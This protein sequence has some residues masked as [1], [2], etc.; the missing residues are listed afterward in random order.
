MKKTVISYRF[1]LL[2]A[3]LLVVPVTFTSCGDDDDADDRT[4]TGKQVLAFYY[5]WYRTPG[6]TGHWYH[7]DSEGHDPD[8]Y[9]EPGRRDIAAIH[10]PTIGA[11]D[12]LDPCVIDH[13]IQQSVDAG[14]DAWII[15]WW[16]DDTEIAAILDRIDVLRSPLKVTAY[17]EFIPG[18][19]SQLCTELTSQEKI[20]A[21][22]T[23]IAGLLDSLAGH[24]AWYTIDGE[25]VLFVYGRAIM[26][27]LF[28][29]NRIIQQVELTHP[30]FISGDT[31]L[32]VGWPVVFSA[33]DQL[34]FYNP[35]GQ[36]HTFGER[37]L[38]YE[39]YCDGIRRRRQSCALTVIPGYDDSAL[40]SRQPII[41]DREGGALYQRLWERAI[42]ADPDWVLIT[43][44]NEWHEGSEIEPSLEYGDNYLTATETLAASFKTPDK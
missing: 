38:L 43:S 6:F 7:W 28:Q 40:P 26:H 33:F 14:I 36:I 31:A 15:S 9:V 16:G 29:W 10:Y 8:Q 11:Y 30:V 35:A 34:H 21:A 19:S 1:P 18:C 42:A 23:D 12:S 3:A 25:P 27:G 44:F 22:A 17:Y 13:H 2:I 4:A 24:P 5:P 32:T 41:I 20:H 39:A 37:S